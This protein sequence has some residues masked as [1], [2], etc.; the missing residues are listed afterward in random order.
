MELLLRFKD[1]LVAFTLANLFWCAPLQELQLLHAS[2][3]VY[4][5][6][7]SPP[8][9][10]EFDTFASLV[11]FWLVLVL[12]MRSGVAFS[13]LAVLCIYRLLNAFSYGSFAPATLNE[14]LQKLPLVH[15][16]AFKVLFATSYG[17][18]LVI[19][20]W[21]DRLS[22]RLRTFCL[23][24]FPFAVLQTLGA[25]GA[26]VT[27]ATPSRFAN[28]A[29]LP[30]PPA[31]ANHSR[32]VWILFDEWDEELVF[33]K[34]PQHLQLPNLDRLAAQSFTATHATAPTNR[35]LSSIPA[36][37]TGRA[38]ADADPESPS[39]LLLKFA[40]SDDYQSLSNLPTIFSEARQLGWTSGLVGWYHPYGRLLAPQLNACLWHSTAQTYLRRAYI[41][42]L[43]PWRGA[44]ALWRDQFPRARSG[45]IPGLSFTSFDWSASDFS[46][47]DHLRLAR[48]LHQDALRLLRDG[49]LHL[50]F[51]HYPV[52][53]PPAI[54]DR[55]SHQPSFDRLHSYADNLDLTDSLLGDIHRTLVSSGEW[56]R[57]TLILSSDHPSRDLWA[58][59]TYWSPE[60]AALNNGGTHDY[61]P[62]LVHLPRQSQ[63]LRYEK[64]FPTLATHDLILALI[65]SELTT[66]G[67]LA[68]WM[69][70][71]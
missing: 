25:L 7:P 65:R 54:W 12:L 39:K 21:R 67:E 66:P 6:P 32:I 29:T 47:A 46:R 62:F 28:L 52:P 5:L 22:K 44:L 20:A 68:A 38:V 42:F 41:E 27:A 64:A 43:G 53:H 70:G 14:F 1:L 26:A 11:L 31:S 57:T 16:W 2:D 30:A 15:S 51:L 63:P 34:R 40:G 37:L 69:S 13:I 71:R 59:T 8:H 35:T 3:Q 18:L 55:S 9:T 10:L 50:L 23:I 61:V 19:P 17:V 36:L 60:S 56:D 49:S 4:F 24:L 58:T 48:D 33:S 45:I